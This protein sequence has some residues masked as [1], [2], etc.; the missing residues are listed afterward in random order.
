MSDDWRAQYTRVLASA[1][2]KRL[3]ES[4]A[5]AQRWRCKGCGVF[6]GL[7]TRLE[8]HHLHYRTL[9]CETAA[10]VVA[11]C[12]V[13]HSNADVQRAASGWYARLEGWAAARGYRT[14]ELTEGIED[15]FRV[16]LDRING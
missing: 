6:G 15:E 8:L 16:W 13:C 3:R 12:T 2:W 11:L 5:A 1:R 7:K 9:G 4:V 14:E 10:D